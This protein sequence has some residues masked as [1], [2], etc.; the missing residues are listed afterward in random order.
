MTF[1]LELTLPMV[2]NRRN[3]QYLDLLTALFVTVLLLSGLLS[4][5]KIIDTGLIVSGIPL[6]FDAGTLLFP[7]SYIFGD[8]LTEVYGYGVSRRVIWTGFG[9]L[10]LLGG[11][12]WLA[13]ILPGESTWES[14]AGQ[15]AYDA[16]LGGITG[17]LVASISAYW[18]GGFTNSYVLSKMK[19]L[20][21]GRFV[22]SRTIGSTLI[23]QIVDT[24]LF[25]TIAVALGVFPAALL[26]SLIFTNYAM[27]V[28]IELIFTPITLQVIKWLKVQEQEDAFDYS[29][30]YNPFR[31]T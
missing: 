28:A 21:R 12:V 23:G 19:L 15:A 17:L 2:S 24:T 29:T 18:A 14:Y 26:T 11:F 10:L 25:F 16:I 7:L 1:K 27:K 9:A 13:G 20:T 4:S 6:V 3:Y 8:V 31:A 22:W 5:A 30:D